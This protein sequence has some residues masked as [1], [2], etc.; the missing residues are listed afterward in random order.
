MNSYFLL[1]KNAVVDEFFV[2]L[3]SFKTS[4]ETPQKKPFSLDSDSEGLLKSSWPA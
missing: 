3:L 4:R 1:S 2:F